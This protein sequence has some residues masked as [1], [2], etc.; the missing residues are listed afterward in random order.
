MEATVSPS[1]RAHIAR[2]KVAARLVLARL[3]ALLVDD[4]LR[5]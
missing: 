4:W 5:W 2:V 3:A 1:T